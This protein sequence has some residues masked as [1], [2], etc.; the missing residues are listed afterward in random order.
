L[1]RRG[2][3]TLGQTGNGGSGGNQVLVVHDVGTQHHFPRV[4][5]A[6]RVWVGVRVRV[7]AGVRVGLRVRTDV[8]ALV[9]AVFLWLRVVVVVVVVVIYIGGVAVV[10]GLRSVVRVGSVV[11]VVVVVVVPGRVRDVIVVG[12]FFLAFFP[13][14][15]FGFSAFFLFAF[16]FRVAV[17][18]VVVVGVRVVVRVGFGF[19]VV[20]VVAFVQ[21][22]DIIVRKYSL[23]AFPAALPPIAL[24][25]D[26]F[27]F[28]PTRK[29]QVALFSRVESVYTLT[30]QYSSSRH[31]LKNFVEQINKNIIIKIKK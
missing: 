28:R 2:G 27:Y 30:Y 25:V 17:F 11:V 31:I 26:D 19:G 15:C 1:R 23:V 10:V 16:G 4:R 8:R 18:F 21:N 13:F 3:L 29:R 7:R 9:V 12:V 6:V 5:V 24:L 22:F 14:S 20:V